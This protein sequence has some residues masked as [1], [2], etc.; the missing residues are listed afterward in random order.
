MRIRSGFVSNSSSCS[1]IVQLK[2]PI[3][4]FTFEEFK[5]LLNLDKL[6]NPY[7]YCENKEKGAEQLFNALFNALETDLPKFKAPNAYEVELGDLCNMEDV[8]EAYNLMHDYP[9]SFQDF[10]TIRLA[11]DDIAIIELGCVI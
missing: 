3:Q 6:N 7:P 4:Q 9:Y 10:G 1:F 11:T 2:K 5:S 8:E